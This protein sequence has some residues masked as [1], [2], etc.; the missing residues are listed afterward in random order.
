MNVRS[1]ES[2]MRIE[3]STFKTY[4]S[5]FLVQFFDTIEYISMS[6]WIG[7]VFVLPANKVVM[8]EE[9]LYPL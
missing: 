6:L 8:Y 4:L 2:N 1:L 7:V 3:I 9:G 5:T